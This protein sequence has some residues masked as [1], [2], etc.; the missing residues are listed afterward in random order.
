[1]R[2]GFLRCGLTLGSCDDLLRGGLSSVH[3]DEPPG[4]RAPGTGHVARDRDFDHHN[5]RGLGPPQPQ[6]DAGRVLQALLGDADLRGANQII[7][8]LPES[9]SHPAGHYLV[10]ANHHQKIKPD[11]EDGR[12]LRDFYR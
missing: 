7:R 4:E 6:L 5:W 2:S 1:M 9:G 3:R 10:G 12:R 11:P 8:G